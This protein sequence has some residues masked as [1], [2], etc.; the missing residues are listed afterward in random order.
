MKLGTADFIG[1]PYVSRLSVPIL[2]RFLLGPSFVVFPSFDAALNKQMPRHFFDLISLP[3]YIPRSIAI[4]R[5]PY[6]SSTLSQLPSYDMNEKVG[7]SRV[8]PGKKNF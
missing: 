4:V 6:S 5:P 8:A 2:Y 3:G 1:E 7:V